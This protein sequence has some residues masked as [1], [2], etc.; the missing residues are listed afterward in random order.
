MVH[1]ANVSFAERNT[2]ADGALAG[3][4]SSPQRRSIQHSIEQARQCSPASQMSRPYHIIRGH[5]LSRV[6]ASGL[7]AAASGEAD[8]CRAW[9]PGSAEVC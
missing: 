7:P 5:I 8:G 9:D 6:G 1:E 3:A 4:Y 2:T